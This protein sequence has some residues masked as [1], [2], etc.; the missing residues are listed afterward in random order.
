VFLFSFFHVVVLLLLTNSNNKI[1]VILYAISVCYGWAL[2]VG[3]TGNKR[4]DRLAD[5]A[6]QGDTE[7][8]F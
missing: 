8:H 4:A 5:E 6:V 3:A 2:H 7:Y 1:I